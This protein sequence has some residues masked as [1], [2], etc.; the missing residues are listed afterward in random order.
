[1]VLNYSGAAS[2]QPGIGAEIWISVIVGLI[3]MFFGM[4]FA[5]WGIATLSGHT[6]DTGMTWGAPVPGDPNPHAE[7]SPI[8]YWEISGSAALQDCA[9]FLFGFAMI[10]EAVV[11]WAV[12]SRVRAK[13][14]LLA[15]ALAITLV[16][17]LLNVIVSGKL[18]MIGVLPFLSL[19]AI[20]FGG[21]IAIYEWR[22]Y[23]YFRSE[24]KRA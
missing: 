20:A 17:T 9:I 4:N 3:L 11:L 16:A 10:L 19:L 8:G 13:R 23:K 7:G 5:R 15:F 21:Y 22:L 2:V 18:F 12:H 24:P 6:Y 14:P 1:L